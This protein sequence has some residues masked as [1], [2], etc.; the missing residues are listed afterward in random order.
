MSFSMR[1]VAEIAAVAV[2]G[3]GLSRTRSGRPS[4]SRIRRPVTSQPGFPV[5]SVKCP[6][7]YHRHILS[8]QPSRCAWCGSRDDETSSAPYKYWLNSYE[9]EESSCA[10]RPMEKRRRRLG[11]PALR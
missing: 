5:A 3:L 4:R 7:S 2:M 9:A 8:L 10:L 11:W 6:L 1:V